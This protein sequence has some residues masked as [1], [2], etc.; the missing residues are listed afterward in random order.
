MNGLRL[1]VNTVPV[2]PAA[3]KKSLGCSWPVAAQLGSHHPAKPGDINA[4]KGW[5]KDLSG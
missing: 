2:R 4:F 3:L 1:A 5:A